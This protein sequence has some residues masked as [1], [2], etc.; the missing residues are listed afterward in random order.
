[1]L[2]DTLTEEMKAAMKA[3][4]ME[5]LGVIRML[6]SAIK[7]SE[8][9]NGDLSDDQMIAVVKSE[10]KKMRDAIEQF[11]NAGRED[12]VSQEESKL[13]VVEE[14]LPEEMSTDAIATIVDE[15]LAGGETDFGK[16]MGQVMGRVNGQADGKVVQE[17]VKQK[18]S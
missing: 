16:V 14:F 11:S 1:M 8:I 5:R 10:R 17:I 6:L 3:R 9:D 18:L 12:L 2:K 7:N 13:A 4:A 15:V